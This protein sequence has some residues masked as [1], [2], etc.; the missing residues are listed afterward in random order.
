MKYELD[1]REEVAI[2]K[3]KNQR[4]DSAIA[5]Q[6][7]SEFVTLLAADDI[8]NLLLDLSEVQFADSSGLSSILVAHRMTT[9]KGGIFGLVGAQPAVEKLIGI[10]HLDRVLLMYDNMEDAITD[11]S[12][13]MEEEDPSAD[14]FYDEDLHNFQTGGKGSGKKAKSADDDDDDD[15]SDE[16]EELSEFPDEDESGFEGEDEDDDGYTRRR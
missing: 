10:S 15:L 16:F 11:V 7:K 14:P 3:L 6:V 1:K 2:F 9:G 13:Q 5:S 4:L 12:I 8:Q